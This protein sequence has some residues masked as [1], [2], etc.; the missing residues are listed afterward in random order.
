MGAGS[1]R[2]PWCDRASPGLLRHQLSGFL[3]GKG[4]FAPK[5]TP[6]LS[7]PVPAPH[8][9]SGSCH[10]SPELSGNSA[11]PDTEPPTSLSLGFPMG[12]AALSG[13]ADGCAPP[14]R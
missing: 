2:S 5:T 1:R 3:P 6:C 4:G 7:F 12:I 14:P 9:G 13:L 11:D 10:V 8:G